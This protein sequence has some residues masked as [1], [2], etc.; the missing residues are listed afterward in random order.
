MKAG[1]GDSF[2]I[3]PLPWGMFDLRV[4]LGLIYEREKGLK[5]D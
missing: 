2:K 5:L 4:P 3:N 1:L